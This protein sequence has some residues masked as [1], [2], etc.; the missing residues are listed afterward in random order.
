M[1]SSIGAY[2]C[3]WYSQQYSDAQG[4]VY[5]AYRVCVDLGDGVGFTGTLSAMTGLGVSVALSDTGF[6][7]LLSSIWVEGVD[8]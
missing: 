3:Y 1:Q 5:Q 4:F 2:P 8:A 6:L 7:D